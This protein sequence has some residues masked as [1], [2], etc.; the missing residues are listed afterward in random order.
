MT[1]TRTALALG[2]AA[3]LSALAACELPWVSE[4]MVNGFVPPSP[5]PGMEPATP[6]VPGIAQ[7]VE[8]KSGARLTA[9]AVVAAG[10]AAGIGLTGCPGP[11]SEL[12]WTQ[13]GGPPVVLLAGRSQAVS[14]EPPEPGSYTFEV[15]YR[16]AQ[17]MAGTRSAS[18]TATAAQ[19]GSR[20]TLRSDQAVRELG[21]TSV[22][23]WPELAPG[24]RLAEISWQQLTGPAVMLDTSDPR[25]LI[26]KAPDVGEDA[27]LTFRA[28]MRTMRGSVDTDDVVVVVEQ[29]PQPP[30]TGMEAVFRNHVSR[31]YPYRR[32][33]KYA[34]RLVGCVFDAQL[35]VATLCP[36]SRLPLLGQEAEAGQAPTI[37]QILDR[38]IVSHDW[39]GANFEQFL[40]T[41]DPDGD[42]RR[43]LA[44]VT[45][46]AIGVHVR[47]SVFQGA[48]GAIY[49]D[50]DFFWLNAAERDL[51]DE[52]PDYRSEFDDELKFSAISRWIAN[53]DRAWSSYRRDVRTVRSQ[54]FLAG[55]L[56]R[57]LYHEL[58]HA[59][60]YFP[61]SIHASLDAT[62]TPYAVFLARFRANQFASTILGNMFPLTSAEMKSLGKVMFAGAMATD[63]E[64]GYLPDTVAGFFRA[65]LANDSYNYSTARED[66]AMMTEEFLMAHRRGIRRD[67][68]ITNKLTA[69]TT[70]DQLLLAWGQRG[71][72]GEPSLRSRLRLVVQQILPWIDPAT[73]ENLPPPVPLT[74]GASWTASIRLPP[75]PQAAPP[76][77]PP[78]EESPRR[79]LELETAARAQ[80]LN[81]LAPDVP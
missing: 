39:L 32:N 50:A 62:Q 68:A 57:L 31:V 78:F 71:R 13:T 58:A 30:A 19:T 81:L 2:M 77:P 9:D 11:L 56:T 12:T 48:T 8:C 72:I 66:L 6:A 4:D 44:A 67:L 15:A 70:G 33:G 53:G 41:Q 16:D 75:T 61:L 20:L 52:T 74:V 54:A 47:P 64:K 65:D 29:L 79:L 27:A 18:V 10:K 21:N 60:E 76:P 36:L 37:D 22:R 23:A 55:A 24:D 73:V 43:M 3:T 45:A 26:F 14:F 1:E 59:L 28:T 51:I 49:L 38:V 34:D 7:E 35:T 63:L 40:L 80:H 25:R 42:L 5:L 46:I 69:T 17:G